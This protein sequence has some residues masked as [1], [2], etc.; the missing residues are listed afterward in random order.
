MP[1]RRPQANRGRRILCSNHAN[2]STLLALGDTRSQGLSGQSST[3]ASGGITEHAVVVFRFAANAVDKSRYRSE[4]EVQKRA[5]RKI[6]K[7]F[8]EADFWRHNFRIA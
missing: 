2:A 5:W 7:D 4:I 3:T 1:C 8:L 6:N